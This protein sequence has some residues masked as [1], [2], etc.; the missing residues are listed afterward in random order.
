MKKMAL[1]TMMA[2]TTLTLVSGP[3]QAQA[4]AAGEEIGTWINPHGSVKVQTGQCGDKLCGWVVWASPQA[5]ADAA[6]GGVRQIV[7]TVLLRD[8]TST[9]PGNWEGRV[10][11]PDM[12]HTY[13]STISQLDANSL[14]ISGCVLGGLICK[15]QVWHRG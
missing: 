10:F 4:V 6:A 14:K 3:V 8:Y 1:W 2:A 12:G 5:T 11:V 13:Y 15:S 9:R 7:G